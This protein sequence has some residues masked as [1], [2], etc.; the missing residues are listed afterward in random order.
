MSLNRLNI[1]IF[2]SILTLLGCAPDDGP[3]IHRPLKS[4]SNTTT[5]TLPGSSST[6]T[7]VTSTST[8]TTQPSHF[9]YVYPDSIIDGQSV[10]VYWS[11]PKAS[12]V[13]IVGIGGGLPNSGTKI[14]YPRKTS[15]F[16]LYP[17]DPNLVDLKANVKVSS[18]TPAPARFGSCESICAEGVKIGGEYHYCR[19]IYSMSSTGGAGSQGAKWI[20]VEDYAQILGTAQIPTSPYCFR[21]KCGNGSAAPFSWHVPGTAYQNWISDS[22]KSALKEICGDGLDNDCDGQIDEGC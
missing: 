21:A 9:F 13:T 3:G 6:S 18:S 1:L 4:T 16:F 2:I 14:L 12:T 19:D 11:Y 20:M 15:T 7:T 8:S 10:A 17:A 5:T 22:A